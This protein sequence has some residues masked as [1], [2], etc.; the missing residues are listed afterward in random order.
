MSCAVA[1]T[2]TFLV[3]QA[4]PFVGDSFEGP[5]L[6]DNQTPPGLWSALNAATGQT[7]TRSGMSAKRGL[8]GILIVDTS[9]APTAASGVSLSTSTQ[10]VTDTSVFFRFWFRLGEQN[11]RGSI[12]LAQMLSTQNQQATLCDLQLD[13]PTQE[14]VMTGVS[15]PNLFDL[16]RT[17]STVGTGQWHLLECAV[18]GLNS[19]NGSRIAFVDGA[20]VAAKNDL[21]LTNVFANEVQI[22]QPFAP[23]G[24]YAGSYAIDEFRST[25]TL[26]ASKFSVTAPSTGNDTGRCQAINYQLVTS[27]N[28]LAAP[29]YAFDATVIFAGRNVFLDSQ[30][31]AALTSVAFNTASSAG[32]FFV[33]VPEGTSSLSLQYPDFLPASVTVFGAQTIDSGPTGRADGGTIEPSDGGMIGQQDPLDLDV[34]CGCNTGST[35]A[36]MLLF[37]LSRGLNR[38]LPKK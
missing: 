38:P 35:L 23:D 22:G 21:N 36:A 32:T 10:S 18:R 6:T 24:R 37:L 3:L 16:Q 27:E 14:V 1:L 30:C 34:R 29:P 20:Q 28:N 13:F 8:A 26:G 19:A 9:E 12:V 17:G 25:G 31:S 33:R 15:V 2:V 7:L 5:N 4:G 11:A